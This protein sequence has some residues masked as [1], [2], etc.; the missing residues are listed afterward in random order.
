MAIAVRRGQRQSNKSFSHIE[1]R[2]T[3]DHYQDTLQ[4][5]LIILLGERRMNF[6]FF[7]QTPQYLEITNP[8]ASAHRSVRRD[9]KEE[10][11]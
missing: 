10:Q 9:D 5:F 1:I 8:P 3:L 2:S 4:I 6:L 7:V 11:T